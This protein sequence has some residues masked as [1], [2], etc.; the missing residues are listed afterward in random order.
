MSD[1]EWWHDVSLIVIISTDKT[2]EYKS[3]ISKTWTGPA[4]LQQSKYWNHKYKPD[5]ECTGEIGSDNDSDDG[6]TSA[7]SE[8][9]QVPKGN[10][11]CVILFFCNCY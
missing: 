4:I 10:E 1:T 11:M 2:K 5:A 3:I 8:P 9:F 7:Q 6:K